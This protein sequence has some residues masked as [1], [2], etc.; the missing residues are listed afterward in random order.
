MSL[1]ATPI[2]FMPKM[3]KWHSLHEV[4]EDEHDVPGH[5]NEGARHMKL[6]L[7][8]YLAG[9]G[10]EENEREEPTRKRTPQQKSRD[11]ESVFLVPKRP[12]ENQS[13]GN[14]LSDPSGNRRSM[15]S[16]RLG[17]EEEER[18]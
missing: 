8:F 18:I 13:N 7:P 16:R 9:F 3:A 14:K 4:K 12:F 17:N 10:L 15:G 2:G 5:E 6:S 11:S 1:W